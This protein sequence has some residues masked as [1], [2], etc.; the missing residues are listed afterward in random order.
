MAI[1]NLQNV[2]SLH[3]L[4]LVN[5]F[6]LLLHDQVTGSV[7]LQC[8][9]LFALAFTFLGNSRSAGLVFLQPLTESFFSTFFSREL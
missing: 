1:L 9:F 2:T 6:H 4:E 8:Y 7:D 5:V 3:P